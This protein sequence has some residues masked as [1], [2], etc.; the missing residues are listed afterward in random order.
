MSETHATD[1]KKLIETLATSKGSAQGDMK[2][3]AC[4]HKEK[5]ALPRVIVD[6]LEGPG[7]ARTSPHGHLDGGVKVI[8]NVSRNAQVLRWAATSA[9][10]PATLVPTRMATGSGSCTPLTTG[11]T[12]PNGSTT[13]DA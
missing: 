7:C 10:K 11:A 6:P 3:V 4:A 8:L 1:P 9:G 5:Q 2:I 13:G 12:S